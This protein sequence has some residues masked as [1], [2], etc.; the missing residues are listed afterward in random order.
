M[1]TIDPGHKY[2]LLN[3]DGIGTQTLTFVKRFDPLDRS[4]YPGNSDAHEGTTIQSVIRALLE[5]FRFLQNQIPCPEN[6]MCISN[7]KECL[8]MLENRAS[9]RHGISFKL[10]AEECETLPMCGVCGHVIC[11]HETCPDC[12]NPLRDDW[13]GVRACFCTWDGKCPTAEQI[14]AEVEN[15]TE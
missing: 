8:W 7:L 9:Q 10:T 11:G 1:K 4:K 12:H 14:I 13:H 3:L 6:E 15:Q 2:E 5:R